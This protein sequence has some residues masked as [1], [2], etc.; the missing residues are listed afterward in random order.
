MTEAE[1]T[2]MTAGFDEH[3]I[4]HGNPKET[5]ER[6]GF[7]A[8]NREKFVGCSSGLAYKKV[9]GY[10]NWFYLTELFIETP[11]RGQCLGA[12]LLRKLEE[13]VASLGIRNVWTWT[14]SYE[15]PGFYK[16]QGYEI[17]CEMDNW[18]ASDHSRVGLRKAGLL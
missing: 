3:A 1:F 11:F 8:M 17:F 10:G 4:E 9:I 15:A 6:F 14:A 5:S 18:Y 2:R 12:E 7:V 16:K 13:R